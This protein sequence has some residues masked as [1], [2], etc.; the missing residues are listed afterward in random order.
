[1][2]TTAKKS[3]KLFQPQN[4]PRRPKHKTTAEKA[5]AQQ[6]GVD[7]ES[8]VAQSLETAGWKVVTKRLKTP[9]G[10]ID[11]IAEKPARLLIVEVKYTSR[12]GT[13]YIETTLPNPK[14]Q[15]RILNASQHFLN[16]TPK[17]ASHGIDFA[18]A[19]V[20]KNGSIQYINDWFGHATDGV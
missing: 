12:L 7:A 9:Y 8:L 5:Q 4:L 1:M 18:V 15:Q 20:R 13:G 3:A 6:Q 2:S 14:Q 19:I 16:D 10:E 17:Y 11:L